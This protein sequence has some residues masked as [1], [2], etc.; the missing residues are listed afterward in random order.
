MG[1]SGQNTGVEEMCREQCSWVHCT[2]RTMLMGSLHTE[3]NAHGF[4][5]QAIPDQST[6]HGPQ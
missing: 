5:A 6:A 3:N 2:Q 4:T 1:F